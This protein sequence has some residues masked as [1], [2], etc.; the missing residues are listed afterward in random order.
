MI[1]RCKQRNTLPFRWNC[2]QY[3]ENKNVTFSTIFLRDVRE[4]HVGRKEQTFQQNAMA[5]WT[6]NVRHSA[7]FQSLL[8]EPNL[9]TSNIE[10]RLRFWRDTLSRNLNTAT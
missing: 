10:T 7:L 1:L 4:G 6:E 5:W 8:E 3:A 2:F 9:K